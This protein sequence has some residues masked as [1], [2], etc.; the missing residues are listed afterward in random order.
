MFFLLNEIVPMREFSVKTLFSELIPLDEYPET[1]AEGPTSTLRQAYRPA[2]VSLPASRILANT[3]DRVVC[4]FLQAQED[5]E[6]YR[7]Q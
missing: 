4:Q 5:S 6:E 7:V 2:H 3:L 1:W